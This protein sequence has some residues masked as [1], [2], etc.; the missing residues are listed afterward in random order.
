MNK[1]EEG[2]EKGEAWVEATGGLIYDL[3]MHIIGKRGEGRF[4]VQDPGVKATLE[5]E[6][7]K[8]FKE[9]QSV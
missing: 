8:D 4:A 3:E 6:W 1:E 5:P 9:D 2:G 7:I